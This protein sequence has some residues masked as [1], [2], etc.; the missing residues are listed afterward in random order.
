MPNQPNIFLSYATPDRERVIEVYNFLINNGYPDVWIDSEKILPGQNWDFEIKRNLQKADIVIAF[1]SHN[2]VGRRGYVQREM[3][4][5]LK[6]LEEKLMD[7][8]Y[9]IPIKIDE[10]V[11][12]PELLSDLQWVYID[13]YNSY[14][15][16][17]A[18]LD[19]QT[20]KLGLDIPIKLDGPSEIHMS[21]INFKES[22][23]GIPGYEVEYT[24]PNFHSKN[25]KNINEITTCINGYFISAL[26]ENR[27]VKIEQNTR[28]Y[29]WT[30][31]K[32]SRM[33]TFDASYGDVYLSENLISFHYSIYS[34]SAGA[35]HPNQYFKTYNFLLEPLL[36][37]KSLS[38]IFENEDEALAELIV[39]TRSALVGEYLDK[40]T[41][42]EEEPI[43]EINESDEESIKE[44][45]KDWKDLSSFTFSKKGINIYFSPYSIASYVMGSFIV[46]IP[47]KA[48]TTR[49]K[50]VFVKAL[51]L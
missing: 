23:D 17:K 26:Q 34:Y 32:Y 14:T 10:D 40:L 3:K 5:M 6:N 42:N 30:E 29:D 16:L 24:I 11:E 13:S 8:I 43:T 27:E 44:G 51:S 9:I 45:T 38:Y 39:L 41:L 19:L 28:F 1:F 35:A 33:S 36:E 50:R 25:Y 48:M 20:S 21:K 22:W 37:I 7:D 31:D 4:L 49:I 12:A 46:Y 2:S 15:K 18:S 47:Y